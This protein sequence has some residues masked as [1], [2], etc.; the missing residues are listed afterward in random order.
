VNDVLSL[1]FSALHGGERIYRVD[2]GRLT[3][4]E[5]ERVGEHRVA[6]EPQVLLRAPTLPPGATVMI[7]HLPN[8]IDGLAV[9]ALA[10]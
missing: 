6:G 8:A 3:A 10:Q 5:V 4:V 2:D 1:P 9:E 7:T